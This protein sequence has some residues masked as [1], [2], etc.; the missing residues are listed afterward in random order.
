MTDAPE[1][2][3]GTEG[4]GG[5]TITNLYFAIDIDGLAGE[6]EELANLIQCL[7]KASTAYSIESSAEKTKLISN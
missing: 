3:K 2:H 7:N 6:T 1:D 4:I 5:S